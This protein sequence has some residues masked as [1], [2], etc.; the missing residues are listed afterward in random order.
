MDKHSDRILIAHFPRIVTLDLVCTNDI[1]E[2]FRG[3]DATFPALE[4]LSL[5]YEPI[6]GSED[7]ADFPGVIECFLHSTGLCR[8]IV[9]G[10]AARRIN[11]AWN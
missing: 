8:V 5:P 10:F 2:I 6:S 7:D 4:N 9:G 3:F 11:I 1:V